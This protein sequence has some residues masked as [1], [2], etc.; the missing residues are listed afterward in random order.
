MS[1]AQIEAKKVMNGLITTAHSLKQVC[2]DL[3][4][5]TKNQVPPVTKLLNACNDTVLIA[6][7]V[8][9]EAAIDVVELQAANE[10]LRNYVT[11]LLDFITDKGLNQEY[12]KFTERYE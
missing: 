6:S 2:D 9:K 8:V 7:T 11:M 4:A 10:C 3:D 12:Y 1:E 5:V